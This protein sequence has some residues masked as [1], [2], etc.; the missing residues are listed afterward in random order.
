[1]SLAPERA[2]DRRGFA[3]ARPVPPAQAG[4]AGASVGWPARYARTLAVAEAT[5]IAAATAVGLIG[6]FGELTA[7]AAIHGLPYVLLGPAFVLAWMGLLAA[8][9]AYEP[10]VLGVGP[11]EFKRV[12]RC[13]L[14][15]AGLVAIVSYVLHV[16]LARGFVALTFPVGTLGLLAERYAARKWLHL[17]RRTGRW[18]HRVL[19]VGGRREVVEM[20][21]TLRREPYAGLAVVGV[22]LPG[23]DRLDA[24]AAR[25]RA[26]DDVPVVG[27]L[28]TCRRCARPART[29]SRSPPP[30][31]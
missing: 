29:R 4:V 15:L 7:D 1:M 9:E 27:S 30:P 23:G 10:R 26:E 21:R 28:G 25:L 31:R 14:Q 12:A 22:C 24:P 2:L 16:E 8:Q 20:V 11:D 19:V 6:R 3:R 17:Q 18:S 13:G 5:V